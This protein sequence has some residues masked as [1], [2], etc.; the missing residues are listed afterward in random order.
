MEKIKDVAG[1]RFSEL[2]KE[3]MLEI[4]GGI[5]GAQPY[6][7][8]AVVKSIVKLTKKFCISAVTG[9]LSFRHC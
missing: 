6:S 1:Q 3:E 2:S 9:V 8:S 7:W 4:T 5:D